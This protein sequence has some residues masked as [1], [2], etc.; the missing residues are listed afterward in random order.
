MKPK[1]TTVKVGQHGNKR[2]APADMG[3]FVRQHSSELLSLPIAPAH[4]QQ[5]LRGDHSHCDR[6]RDLRR[7]KERRAVT[8]CVRALPY[9]AAHRK[10]SCYKSRK[11]EN[12]AGSPDP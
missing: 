10:P 3:E 9:Y 11:E 8:L 7:F 12:D 5:H 4:W 2:V 6:H 1:Q